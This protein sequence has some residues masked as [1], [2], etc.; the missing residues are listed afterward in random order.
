MGAIIP[1]AAFEETVKPFYPKS[2]RRGRTPNGIELM[3]RM[4]FPQVRFNLADESLEE[5]I[6]DSCAGAWHRASFHAV[7][8]RLSGRVLKTMVKSAVP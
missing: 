5:N 8:F 3:P 6:Y 7:I 1:W 4:Y 2:G